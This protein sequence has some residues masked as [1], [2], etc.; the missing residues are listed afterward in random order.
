MTPDRSSAT[1]SRSTSPLT[2][3]VTLRLL[4]YPVAA[5]PAHPQRLLPELP[6]VGA[7]RA[8]VHQEGQERARDTGNAAVP[9]NCEECH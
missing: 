5:D 4:S 1:T 2:W 7:C 3:Q 6:A 8:A 9:S